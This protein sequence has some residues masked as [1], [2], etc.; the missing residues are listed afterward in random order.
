EHEDPLPIILTLHLS[1]RPALNLERL[2]THL[3]RSRGPFSKTTSQFDSE[4]TFEDSKLARRPEKS[5]RR[6]DGSPRFRRATGGPVAGRS[7][8]VAAT[9]VTSAPEACRAG[10]LRAS[11]TRTSRG[12]YRQV[13]K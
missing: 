10:E 6:L 3:R 11:R 5:V 9:F 2:R 12:G 8:Q 13:S 7:V 1:V 4:L